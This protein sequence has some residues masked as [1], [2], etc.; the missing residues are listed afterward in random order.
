MRAARR[1]CFRAER[2]LDGV[3]QKVA[4]KLPAPR[5]VFAGRA[6]A[7]PARSGQALASLAHPNIAHADRRWRDRQWPT[8]PGHGVRRRPADNW[9][10]PATGGLDIRAR[11]RLMV[12]VCRAVAAAHQNLIV[13][14]DLKP[15]NI[16][17]DSDGSVKLLDFGIAQ[18]AGRGAGRARRRH[19]HW[20]FPA[21]SRLCRTG[22]V[23]TAG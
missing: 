4:L 16:L 5:P 9:T 12:V 15:T 13:H 18:V 8:L 11:L 21:H 7:V 14:R 10:M 22:T 3:R 6:T 20:L 2:D 23:R 19:S 17:V 1:W